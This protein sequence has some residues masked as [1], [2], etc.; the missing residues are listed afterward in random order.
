[1]ENQSN[2]LMNTY[3][4]LPI[5]LTYGRGSYLYDDSNQ[6]YLDMFSGIA[7]NALGHNHEKIN[8]A[9]L[10][11]SQKFLHVSNVFLTQ[12]QATL[13]EKLVN[14]SGMSKVF[15]SNSGTEA[16]EAALKIA[17]KWGKTIN[18]SKTD[19]VAFSSGFHGR[20]SAGMALSFNPVYKT[21]FTPLLPGIIHTPFNDSE[22]LIQAVNDNVCAIFLEV[23]QGEGGVLPIDKDFVNTIHQLA[24]KYDILVVI[25]EIQTGLLRTGKYFS[26]QLHDMNPD[27]VTLA[28][29]VGGG[30][31]LGATLVNDKMSHILTYGEHGSTFGGNPLACAL[32]NVVLDEI[33]TPLFQKHVHDQADYLLKALLKLQEN[34]STMIKD[35]RGAGYMIGVELDDACATHIK[36]SFLSH[37]VLVNVTRGN[38][39]RLLPPLNIERE[40]LVLFIETFEL[41]LKSK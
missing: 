24:K 37:H 8:Q 27:I 38:V 32:G 33:M 7:V 15:F 14:I 18:P 1:M 20:S 2:A 39:L 26:Y 3:R 35:V 40:D 19:V 22:A 25:D 16:I 11:Q 34:Y 36:E 9:I 5:N 17:R 21:P 13:A 28:K 29:A 4:R 12:P 31:P 41:I 10:T 30:L 6:A 23:I